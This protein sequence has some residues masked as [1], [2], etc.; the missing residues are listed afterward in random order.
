[1][2]V[3]GSIRDIKA[4]D[5]CLGNERATKALESGASLAEAREELEAAGASIVGHIERARRSVERASGGPWSEL[6]SAGLQ[7]IEKAASAL[8]SSVE[9]LATLLQ[10]YQNKPLSRDQKK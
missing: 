4:L 10:H 9:Q 7:D 3:I 2:R 6:D 1:M 8:Q 5:D